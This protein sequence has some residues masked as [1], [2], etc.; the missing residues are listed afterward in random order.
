M[1]RPGA[2]R[3][4]GLLGRV[5][6]LVASLM[7]DVTRVVTASDPEVDP[8]EVLRPGSRLSGREAKRMAKVAQQLSDMPKVAERPAAGDITFGHATALAN[9]A[10][11]VWGSRLP[12]RWSSPPRQA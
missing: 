11:K 2:D 12:P 5:P 10:D 1:P 6:A 8:A 7:R 9:A 3:T 4:L